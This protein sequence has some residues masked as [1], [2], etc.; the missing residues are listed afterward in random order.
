MASRH[1]EFI[2]A[3]DL[4]P[5][6]AEFEAAKA[7]W[8]VEQEAAKAAQREQKS[9]KALKKREA[10][11]CKKEEDARAAVERSAE[12]QAWWGVADKAGKE[13]DG[14]WPACEK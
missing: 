2:T 1:A 12:I 13:N 10:R 6:W 9:Q 11:R 8:A 4:T 14:V 3:R 7:E 5:M